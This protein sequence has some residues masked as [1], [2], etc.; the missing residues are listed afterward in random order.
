[1][2]RREGH[3]NAQNAKKKYAER[4]ARGESS[5]AATHARTTLKIRRQEQQIVR[6]NAYRNSAETRLRTLLQYGREK[7]GAL[8]KATPDEFTAAQRQ[9]KQPEQNE[10]EQNQADQDRRTTRA[11]NTEQEKHNRER[12]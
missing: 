4:D 11:V 2:E 3:V 5:H 10:E 12:P 8:K 6:E 9:K 1:M 7:R